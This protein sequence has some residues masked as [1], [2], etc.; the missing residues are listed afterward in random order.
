MGQAKE[1]HLFTL[2]ISVLTGEWCPHD[3]RQ[4]LGLNGDVTV[5]EAR[6]VLLSGGTAQ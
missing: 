4:S 1:G 2:P 5:S 3:E 6:G